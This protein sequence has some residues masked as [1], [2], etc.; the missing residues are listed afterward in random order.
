M[1]KDV[2]KDVVLKSDEILH[3]KLVL[4]YKLLRLYLSK[5]KE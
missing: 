3:R 2:Y 5:I 1:M 4:D